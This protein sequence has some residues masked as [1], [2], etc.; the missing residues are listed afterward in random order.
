MESVHPDL[1]LLM[2]PGR[3]DICC[4]VTEGEVGGLKPFHVYRQGKLCAMLFD[5]ADGADFRKRIY[6]EMEH[7][8]QSAGLSG[9]FALAASAR[10]CMAKARIALETGQRE[11]P[12]RV[13]YS[14]EQYGEKALLT[15][16]AEA[17]AAL[18]FVCRDFCHAAVGEMQRLDAREDTR[19]AQSLRAYL[20]CGLNLRQAAEQL[21][22][23]RN[24]LAYRMQRVQERFLLDLTDMNTCFELL[25][26]FWL[27]DNL[28]EAE[29]HVP[30][31]PFDGMQAQAAL[32]CA[33]ERSGGV[34]QAGEPFETVLICAGTAHLTD[35]QRGSL[36]LEL[37]ALPG[38]WV[39][40]LDDDALFF[41]LEPDGAEAFCQAA[42]EA[43]A[44]QHAPIVITQPFSSARIGQ[45]L[46]LCRFAFRVVS[47]P[48]TRMQDIGSTLFFMALERQISLQPYLCEDVL[49]VMDDDA[50]KGTALSRSLYAYLLDFRDMK[51]A[52]HKLGMH[53]NTMEY[54]LHKIEALIGKEP[55]EKKRFMMMC[56]YKMLALP[57]T[58]LC[59]L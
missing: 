9:P 45:K 6:Q 7:L 24:T 32:L 54:Q 14:M 8:G 19:Y 25:F 13:L 36:A 5:E 44:K 37:C 39:C 26:A 4:L 3:R 28:P 47:A 33:A 22:I 53:R 29:E 21:G 11:A 49:R 20:S 48:V 42:S 51:K 38:G 23:H 31:A 30:C 2:Q 10:G 50:T 12:G 59:S 43:C 35:E 17:L 46:R 27:M 15:A 41:A 18:G 56:T 34:P 1:A 52:A 40:A 58:E 55:C 57:D 16:A